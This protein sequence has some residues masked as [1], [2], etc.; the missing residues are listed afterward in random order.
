MVG[1]PTKLATVTWHLGRR[2]P[3]AAEALAEGRA[4]L[5]IQMW[6]RF[7]HHMRAHA[8]EAPKFPPLRRVEN[9]GRAVAFV[10]L[11]LALRASVL[12]FA[13]PGSD[14]GLRVCTSLGADA[15]R[16]ALAGLGEVANLT[17][18]IPKGDALRR[19]LAKSHG[20]GRIEEL[21]ADELK[22]I[23]AR[24]QRSR[25]VWRGRAPRTCSSPGRRSC[26]RSSS[27]SNH[28]PRSS[29][30]RWSFPRPRALRWR[31]PSAIERIGGASTI[32]S[33]PLLAR[34]RAIR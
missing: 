12:R 32:S 31:I 4:Q 29:P 5:D 16:A 8:A 20:F 17:V 3:E 34:S 11:H 33:R 26:G 15:M 25:S 7:Q 14:R 24:W 6:D 19:L 13:A 21:G 18:W 22:V 28:A 30:R 10:P 2:K 1:T 27:G 9:S 23:L